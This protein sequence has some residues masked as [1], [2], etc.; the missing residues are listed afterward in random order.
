LRRIIALLYAFAAL[1]DLAGTK[2]RPIRIVVLWL[3]R[4]VEAIVRHF[5]I[6]EAMESRFD[7][8]LAALSPAYDIADDAARLA[9]SFTALAQLLAVIERNHPP[10]PSEGRISGLVNDMMRKVRS[11]A[12]PPRAATQALPDTS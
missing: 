3:L 9:R 7:P 10:S 4:A 12:V 8:N 1:A 11:L 6:E 5:V 2:P